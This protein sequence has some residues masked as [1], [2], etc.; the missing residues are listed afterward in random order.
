MKY[1]HTTFLLAT[2]YLIHL[3]FISTA[4]SDKQETPYYELILSFEP[5]N[6]LLKNKMTMLI[7]TSQLV[8]NKLNLTIAH[9]A[10]I[11]RIVG[12]GIVDKQIYSSNGILKHIILTFEKPTE[13]LLSVKMEYELEIAD[14]LKRNKISKDWIELNSSSF[15]FPSFKEFVPFKYSMQLDIDNSYQVITSDYLLQ[16]NEATDQF[17]VMSRIPRTDIS[18]AAAKNLHSAEGEYTIVYGSKSNDIL[19]KLASCSDSSLQFLVGYIEEP[20]D[21][22]HKRPIVINPLD[23]TVYGLKNYIVHNSSELKSGRELTR[24]LVYEFS[25]YWFSFANPDSKHAWLSESF[26]EYLSLIFLRETYG[27]NTFE[28]AMAQKKSEI[29]DDKKAL[30]AYEGRPTDEALHHKGPLILHQLEQYIG[31]EQFKKL[32]NRMIELSIDTNEKLYN[33]ISTEFDNSA[34]DELHRLRSSI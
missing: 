4:Q 1:R 13:P 10:K 22:N 12:D 5:E 16:S 24:L 33:L 34:L 8:D 25:H 28:E 15:W 32:L 31:E 11:D 9:V 29:L 21:F 18:F 30:L 23:D 27:K 3:S 7:D 26:A 14:T 17:L 19:K 2:I 20:N 6:K